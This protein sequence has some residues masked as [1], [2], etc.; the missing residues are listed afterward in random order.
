MTEEE[1][2]LSLGNEGGEA[3]CGLIDKYMP[4]VSSIIYRIIGERPED[5]KELTA[6]VFFAAW[7][8]RG[9]LRAGKVKSYL[10]EIARNKAFNFVRDRK[11]WL[12]L[13]EDILFTGDDPQ[14]QAENR[15]LSLKLKNALSKL[16]A[17]KKELFL[18]YYYY[19]QKVKDAAADMN[20]NVSTA[21]TW[22]KRSR[23]ELKEILLRDGF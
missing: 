7:R 17:N 12:P 14:E 20:V 1:L 9:K 8:N 16:E 22:L 6:D 3:L 11:E 4:Y 13:D 2:V 15:E 10:G 21:K 23:D 18:R 5:C 19:G